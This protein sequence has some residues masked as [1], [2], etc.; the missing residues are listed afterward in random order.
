MAGSATP[1]YCDGIGPAAAFHLPSGLL[2]TSDGALILVADYLNQ[3]I[4]MIH[5]T[6]RAVTTVVGNGSDIAFD[7]SE[8]HAFKLALAMGAGARA[9][10]A[11]PST[12]AF[13]ECCAEPESRVFIACGEGVLCLTLAAGTC[14]SCMHLCVNQQPNACIDRSPPHTQKGA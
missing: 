13:D 9:P 10:I 8:L 5:T 4:R 14:V 2:V 7:G 3:R 6:T 11:H 1:G 12:M